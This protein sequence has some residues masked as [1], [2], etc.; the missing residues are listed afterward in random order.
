VAYRIFVHKRKSAGALALLCLLLLALML[1]LP[2]PAFA[3]SN[4]AAI[5]VADRLRAVAG[6]NETVTF[7][8]GGTAE[9]PHYT[10]TF[11]GRDLSR[12]QAAE[13]TSLDLGIA[14]TLGDADASGAPDTIMLAFSHEGELP[15]PAQISVLLPANF[16]GD[17]PSLFSSDEQNG[18]FSREVYELAAEDGYVN[19]LIMSAYPRALSSIDLTMHTG[20]I[21]PIPGETDGTDSLT[22]APSPDENLSSGTE[23]GGFSFDIFALPTPLLVGLGCAVACV[24]VIILVVHLRRRAAIAAMQKGWQATKVAFEE[25]PSL[26]EMMDLEEPPEA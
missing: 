10:W 8:S 13:L 16:E 15:L 21:E 17:H 9:Q 25:I 4:D 19:F 7:W 18:I 26:N 11:S 20:V 5:N 6:T 14:L 23:L 3:A 1:P 2:H 12:Q 24:F 22:P